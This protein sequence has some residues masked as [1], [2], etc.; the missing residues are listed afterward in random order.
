MVRQVSVFMENRAGRLADICEVVA[1]AGANIRGFVIS[2]TAQ[3]GIVRFVL[4]NTDGALEALRSAGFTV[5]ESPVLVLDLSEDRPGGLAAVL[6]AVSDVGVN[7]EY[8][9]SLVERFLAISVEDI[10]SAQKRIQTIEIPLLAQANIDA[11]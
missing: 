7:V 4:S 8:A 5:T 6:K 3:F 10:D 2:D 9:Y 1:S 11:L